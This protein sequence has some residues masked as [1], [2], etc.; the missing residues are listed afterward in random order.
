MKQ[1]HYRRLR[2][3]MLALVCLAMAMPARAECRRG[4][5]ETEKEGDE[6]ETCTKTYL[7]GSN[8]V[9]CLTDSGGQSVKLIVLINTRTGRCVGT[10]EGTVKNESRRHQWYRNVNFIKDSGIRIVC[11][12]YRV[13]KRGCAVYVVIGC[14]NHE[15]PEEPEPPA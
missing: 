11:S 5:G 4:G 10:G 1:R 12:F 2:T 6:T 9:G 7:K 3:V 13:D 8:R 14:P 15:E